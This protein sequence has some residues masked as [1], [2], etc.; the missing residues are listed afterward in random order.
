VRLRRICALPGVI[1]TTTFGHPTFQAGPKRTFAVLD[2][3]EQKDM[4]CL[5]FK[6]DAAVQEG[7]VDNERFFLSK[8]GAR[9][10]W[11]AMKVDGRTSWRLAEELVVA[12]Y[13]R[14]APRRLGR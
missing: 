12:S 6:A 10:G 14:V 4:L 7:L 1:E 9:H 11:T 13:Q 2:D 8:F 3:H 5:V